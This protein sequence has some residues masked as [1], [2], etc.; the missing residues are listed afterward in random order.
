M[1]QTSGNDPAANSAVR[2]LSV[3]RRE[4]LNVLQ[5]MESVTRLLRSTGLTGEQEKWLEAMQRSVQQADYLV[6]AAVPW[7]RDGVEERAPSR[8]FNGIALLEQVAPAPI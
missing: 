3:L 4:L 8:V 6:R 7:E 1:G 2:E 5:G